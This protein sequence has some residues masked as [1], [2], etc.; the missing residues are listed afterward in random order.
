LI[1]MDAEK[2]AEA[3]AFEEKLNAKKKSLKA[4]EDEFK[5]FDEDQTEKRNKRRALEESKINRIKDEQIRLD[6]TL[7]SE[8]KRRVEL[9]KALQDACS[10]Q[11][12]KKDAEYT[13]LLQGRSE[14]IHARLKRLEDE[15]SSLEQSFEDARV[16]IP[17]EIEEVAENLTKQLD[18]FTKS[19]EQEKEERKK[20]EQG[21]E[22]D[23]VAQKDSTTH[24]FDD[25]GKDREGKFNTLFEQ[26]SETTDDRTKRDDKFQS[27]VKEEIENLLRD[28]DNEREM[29][30]GEDNDIVT[31]L[32]R[33]STRLQVS[34]KAVHSSDSDALR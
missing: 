3:A 20:R 27:F 22:T 23:L 21:I 7:K 16:R 6:K 4:L 5:I 30:I 10:K 32:Q 17:K 33:F 19:F 28:L 26:L 29:R 18:E 24:N 9:S 13:K 25:E 34:L 1:K 2:E 11:I 14:R 15:V 31:A 8:I 12:Q